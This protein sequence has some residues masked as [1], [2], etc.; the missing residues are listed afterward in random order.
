MR[1]FQLTSRQY[2][3]VPMTH[4][5]GITS[6]FPAIFGTALCSHL[7]V[8]SA[9]EL[10]RLL[11]DHVIPL[12]SYPSNDE[13]QSNRATS[14]RDGN[15]PEASTRPQFTLAQKSVVLYSVI[16]G[17]G[18]VGYLMFH[19]LWIRGPLRGNLCVFG[20]APKLDQCASK[21]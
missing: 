9:L 1:A 3:P 21:E 5:A 12:H 11:M 16:F 6:A 19:D 15:D 17:A 14:P 8:I 10:G 18:S 7:C 13:G 2:A 4:I 20:A